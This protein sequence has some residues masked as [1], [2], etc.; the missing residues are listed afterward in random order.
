MPTFF[1]I[2]A[3]PTDNGSNTTTTITITPPGSML[4]GDL[5]VVYHTQRGTATF[6][7]TNNGG[8]SWTS[9][10]RTALTTNVATQVHYARFNGTWSANPQFTS[11]AGTNTSAYMLVFRPTVSTNAWNHENESNVGAAAATTITVTGVTPNF[12]ENVTIASWHSADDNTWGNLTG[13]NWEQTALGSQ[14]RNLAGQDAS[15]AFAYQPQQTRQ[16]TTNASLQ[17][18]TLGADATTTRRITFYETE[19]FTGGFDPMGMMGIFGI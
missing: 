4:D 15:S 14:Y 12:D 1:G 11:S 7:I 2:S 8:Q 5:V 3:V 17:Q 18:L 6:S 9:L 10:S 16:A 13:D 19:A